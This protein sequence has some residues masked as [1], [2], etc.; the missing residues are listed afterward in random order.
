MDIWLF[1]AI[2]LHLPAL[3]SELSACYAEEGTVCQC[4]SQNASQKPFQDPFIVR[5]EHLAHCSR[6]VNLY[7]AHP[8]GTQ[9]KSI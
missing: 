3:P 7:L 4:A 5:A 6:H 1:Q 9:S 8:D 2:M